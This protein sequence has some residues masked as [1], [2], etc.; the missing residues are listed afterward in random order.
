MLAIYRP[1]DRPMGSRFISAVAFYGPKTGRLREF[2][3]GVQALIAEHVGGDFRPYTLEQVHATLIALN[4]VREGGTV[5]N[6][7]MLEHTG[8][9][10]EMDLP[11]VMDILARRFAT[12]LRVRIGGFRPEQAVPFTSR[13]QHLAE[14]TFSVQGE[15]FV[16][17]GWPADSLAGAGM[18]VDALRRE[19]NAAGVLHRYHARPADV[20]NDL[21]LVV[22]H[23]A[24]APAGA[25]ARATAAVRDKL[26][27]AP[28][29]LA[30]GLSDVTIVAADS[31]TLAPPV[32]VSGVPAAADDVLALVP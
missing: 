22:G 31:H 12:P 4:G 14:R 24:G 7:Y 20:D 6:E 2:L 15:A 9:R 8:E 27:A 16:L 13:G 19:M 11:R 17:V 32:Y 1:Y 3:T 25:L 23:H 28:A 21:H 18:P 30:I 29:D 5:V 10:R 26:A